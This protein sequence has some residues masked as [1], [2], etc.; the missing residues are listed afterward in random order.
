VGRPP[1]SLLER[2]RDALARCA[3][4][5]ALDLLSQA[6]ADTGLGPE[7]LERLAEA[8]FW[9]D[10]RRGVEIGER[11]YAEYM[12]AGNSRRAAYRALILF[13]DYAV[14]SQPTVAGGWLNRAQRLLESEPESVEHGHLAWVLALAALHSDPDAAFTQ[15][16]QCRDIGER[17]AER[18]L[19]I[20]GIHFQGQALVRQ[21]QTADGMRLLDE[22]MAAAVGGELGS[23]ACAVVYC[24]TMTIC[25]EV[26]D[27][28]RAAEWT[29]V[30]E[31]SPGR[32][33]WATFSG[34]CQV[35]RAGVLRVR[36][37][38]E[39]ALEEAEHGCEEC[40]GLNNLVHVGRGFYEIGEIRLRRRDLPGA[41]DA[42]RKA[43]ELGWSPQPGLALL[44]LAE[45]R[46]DSAA[47]SIGEALA[48]TEDR[49]A[50]AALLPA[51]VEIA[52]AACQVPLARSSADELE[53]IANFFGCEGL[54]A[55][56]ESASGAV[57]LA[58]G[59]GLVASVRFREALRLW[60]EIDAPYEIARARM[61]LADCYRA[62]GAPDEE[63]LEL[64]A[65]R[66]SFERLGAIHDA[67]RAAERLA[68]LQAASAPDRSARGVARTFLFTDIVRSTELLTAIGDEVWA[69]LIRW[70]DD[71][72]TAMF[73]A[74]RGEVVKNTGDG[75]FAAFDDTARA[76][77]CAV[78]VQ[79]TLARH[80]QVHGFAPKVRIGIHAGTAT[81]RSGLDYRGE[82]VHIAARIGALA[83]ADEIVA[84]EST[85][86]AW[87]AERVSP[88]REAQ[89]RGIRGPVPVVT[90]EWRSDPV[91][92][93]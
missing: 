13:L 7:D 6:D 85:A 53:E 15:A 9:A 3:W 37:D 68:A 42:F 41:E 88:V 92:I 29:R 4:S 57:H 2:G 65:A 86:A 17:H 56:A 44:R 38:W 11:C 35:H 23:L 16:T 20:M 1:Q 62:R 45:G 89:L 69:D 81:H 80:R 60:R 25:Q 52:I 73:V 26:A 82:D 79:R 46:I 93:S 63:A 71:T 10:R 58:E 66:S 40:H 18:D 39:R 8:A 72:L 5:E 12:K 70:H 31:Q 51:Q 67:H 47:D 77:E 74:H 59:D 33:A 49:I 75:F 50:R 87:P 28:R 48:T 24:Q 36:G 90:I 22:S 19:E 55:S 54:L 14:T 21:G 78:A 32:R 84:S 76:I 83:D 30:A 34:E 27:L 43:H 91:T 61:A 64:Q